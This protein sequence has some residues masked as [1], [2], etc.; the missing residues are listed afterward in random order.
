MKLSSLAAA[1]VRTPYQTFAARQQW[2]QKGTKHF[3][4]PRFIDPTL[5]FILLPSGAI[6]FADPKF[7]K[8]H[9]LILCRGQVHLVLKIRSLLR[10]L[11]LSLFGHLFFCSRHGGEHLSDFFCKFV[12]CCCSKWEAFNQSWAFADLRF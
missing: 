7:E 9:Q 1:R 11:S 12:F 8:S 3:L 10:Q 4:H 2:N 6:W 5:H